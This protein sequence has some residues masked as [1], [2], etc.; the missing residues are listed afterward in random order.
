MGLPLPSPN[1]QNLEEAGRFTANDSPT[2][3][4]LWTVFLSTT[5]KNRGVPRNGLP[6]A[7]SGTTWFQLREFNWQ[8]LK[9]SS[10]LS[11]SLCDWTTLAR[12]FDVKCH[13]RAKFWKI[14]PVARAKS[15]G[16][17][18]R[19][20]K[21]RPVTVCADAEQLLG[22]KWFPFFALPPLTCQST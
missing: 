7:S 11:L 22:C 17:L 21:F 2:A 15:N 12:T 5:R 4:S 18:Q 13:K 10:A 14:C 1:L 3:A 16:K 19:I 6:V 8:K 20:I 9:R